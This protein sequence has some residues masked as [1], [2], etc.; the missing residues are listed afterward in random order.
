MAE[1]KSSLIKFAMHYGLL[2]GLYWAFKYLFFI[3]SFYYPVLNGVYIGMTFFVPVVAYFFSVKYREQIGGVITFGHAWQLG[4][5]LYLFAALIVSLLHYVYYQFVLPPGM[6]VDIY[7]QLTDYIRDNMTLSP[8]MSE[9]LDGLKT[10]TPI[11]M[12]LQGIAN[13]VFYGIILSIPI[14]L[15]VRR[16]A[17]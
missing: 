2:M 3:L 9:L 12:T 7:S 16:K 8:E 13:N 5:Y 6:L 14:A 17:I 15:A 4:V 11:Q 10:P 1:N